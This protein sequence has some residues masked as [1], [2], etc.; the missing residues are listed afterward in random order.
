MARAKARADAIP[1][2]APQHLAD[3][4]ADRLRPI[5]RCGS[6]RPQRFGSGDASRD[7]VELQPFFGAHRRCKAAQACLV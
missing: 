7:Q 1:H 4:K 2:G 3:D 5:A 6:R